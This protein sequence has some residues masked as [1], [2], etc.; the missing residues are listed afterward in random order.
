MK[1]VCGIDPGLEGG[2]CLLN[3]DLQVLEFEVMPTIGKEINI[4]RLCDM[5]QSFYVDHG[6]TLCVLERAGT[7]PGQ[8][9]QSG[10]KTGRNYGILEGIVSAQNI[11][12]REIAPQTWMKSLA[13]YHK[14]PGANKA[15]LYKASKQRNVREAQKMF[16]KVDLLATERSKVPHLGKV[17]ALL[18]AKFGLSLL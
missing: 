7:R 15:Q 3:Q 5:L 2:I 6:I 12:Y 14:P 13:S 1:T 10:L 17:D 18:L 11:P 4:R 8:S 16:P 9:S